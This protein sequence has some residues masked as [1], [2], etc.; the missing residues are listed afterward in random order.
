MF[1]ARKRTLAHFFLATC[2]LS[3]GAWA[4]GS[5]PIPA[6][7][8]TPRQ[9]RPEVRQLSAESPIAVADHPLGAALDDLEKELAYLRRE[10]HDF[11]CR[12]VKRERINGLLQEYQY[13]DMWVREES[14]DQGGLVSPLAVYMEFRGPSDF[15]GRRALFV[16]GQND[17]K[18]LVRKG[19]NRF[20]YVVTQIAPDGPSARTESLLPITQSGFSPMLA[21]L[22]DVLE[23][24][25]A[26]DPSGQNTNVERIAGAKLNDRACDVIKISHPRRQDNLTFH[27]IS[28]FIDTELRVPVRIAKLDWPE[29]SDDAPPVIAEYNYTNVKLNVGLADRMFDERLLK[30][31]R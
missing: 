26:A 11:T 20:A 9:D 22:I 4:W 29:E 6:G 31:K 5:Q 19:G 7:N 23:L 1:V 3:C 30:A 24:H 21:A 12:V 17:G 16:D 28:I 18:V 13:I 15:A 10:V 27:A 2:V 25:A 8:I 14:R